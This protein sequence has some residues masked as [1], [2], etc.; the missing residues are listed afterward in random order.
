MGRSGASG[1]GRFTPGGLNP[2]VLPPPCCGLNHG[3]LPLRAT[4]INTTSMCQRKGAEERLP[5]RQR[6]RQVHLF[7]Y[8]WH[9]R[10]VPDF[11]EK[12]WMGLCLLSSMISIVHKFCHPSAST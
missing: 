7:W 6:E 10:S 11:P 1:D 12:K 3:S 9:R 4:A 8:H 5:W 2:P